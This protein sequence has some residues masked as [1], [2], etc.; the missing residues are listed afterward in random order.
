MRCVRSIRYMVKCNLM[1]SDIII[2]ERGLRQGDPLSPYFFFKCME[3]L[4]PM[5]IQAQNANTIKGIR[6]SQ[7]GLSINHLFFADDAIL[8]VRNKKSE[9]DEFMKILMEFEKISSQSINLDKSMVYFSP[10]TPVSQRHYFGSLLKMKVVDK[11]DNY[12]GLPLIVGKKKSTVFKSIS[13]RISSRMNSWSKRLLSY[14]GKEVFIKSVLQSIPTYAFS[15]FLAPKGVIEELHSK[16]S[17]LWDLHLFNIAL[18]G[19]QVWRLITYKD[20][21][22]Y[23]VILDATIGALKTWLVPQ[24]HGYFTSKSAYSWLIL[25]K[26][27]YGPHRFFWRNIWKL[28]T[29]P[30]IRIF[31][32]RIGHE[33]LPTYK[34]IAAIRK[35]FKTD[36][37]RCG[38]G[39]ETLLHALKDC[40]IAR[41][42]LVM[43]G[44]DSSLLEG[45][46]TQCIDRIEEVMRVLDIKAISD[47][48]TTLWNS[49]NNRNNYIFRGKEDDARVVWERARTLNDDFQEDEF[50]DDR[51]GFGWLVLG[52]GIVEINTQAEWTDNVSMVNQIN[53]RDKDIPT[54]GHQINEIC[55]LLKGFNVAKII[56]EVDA[57]LVVRLLQRPY[58]HT[59]PFCYLL[60]DC[61]KLIEEGWVTMV[62]QRHR[63]GNFCANHLASLAQDLAADSIVLSEPPPSLLPLLQANA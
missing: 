23:R 8:F 31:C 33:I 18:L 19:R 40:P 14:G 12:L 32:W 5:L 11:L 38:A 46:F 9:V 35:E 2:R 58:M 13:N 47:F 22:C 41:E 4:S 3:V 17:R 53:K 42:I 10:N 48:I 50:W 54:M 49:W 30:K 24:P 34:K 26:V 51:E 59:H 7:N 28:Q 36:C 44:I 39:E 60:H 20:T 21:L 29:L 37:P 25:N 56:V 43:G 1:L 61:W 57:L 62:R 52:S 45:N 6:A 27:G 15:V 63:E 55:K 16:I